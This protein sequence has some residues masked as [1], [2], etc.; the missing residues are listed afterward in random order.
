MKVYYKTLQDPT[1]SVVVIK[2]EAISLIDMT[3]VIVRKKLDFKVLY[4]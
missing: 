3:S 4:F 2:G 1:I